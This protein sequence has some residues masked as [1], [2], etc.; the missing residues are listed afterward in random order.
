MKF[1]FV[2]KLLELTKIVESPTSYLEWAAYAT[3]AAV[4][5]HNVYYNFPARRTK[6]MPNLYV[7]IVGDSGST[8][9]S[10][11]LKVSNFL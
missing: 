4:L 2:E 6:I 5:R 3:I 10:T 9:K 1:N 7:L 11:P 8:R